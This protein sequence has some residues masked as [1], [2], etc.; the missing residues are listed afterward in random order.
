[1]DPLATLKELICSYMDGHE[2]E[3]VEYA[4]CLIDWIKSGGFTPHRVAI[5]LM[6]EGLVQA[7]CEETSHDHD[8]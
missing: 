1:M 8:S 3:T 2:D 5:T 6:L 7:F 4:Q